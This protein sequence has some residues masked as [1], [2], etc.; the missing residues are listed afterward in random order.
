M[1]KILAGLL[2]LGMFAFWGCSYFDFDDESDYAP[3]DHDVDGCWV[4]TENMSTNVGS[5]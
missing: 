1:K 4:S 2:L 5:F 3:D